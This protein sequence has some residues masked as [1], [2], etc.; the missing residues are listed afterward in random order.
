MRYGVPVKTEAGEVT[1]TVH[2]IDWREPERND[3]AVAEEVTLRGGLERR[4]DL[5]ET[6]ALDDEERRWL[7]EWSA[8]RTGFAGEGSGES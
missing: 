2:L 3:F 6:A 4:P 1:Q 7:D 5:L 8:A